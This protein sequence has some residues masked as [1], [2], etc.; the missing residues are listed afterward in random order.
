LYS[1]FEIT[2]SRE[3]S[4]LVQRAQ[5]DRS[6]RKRLRSLPKSLLAVSV[7]SLLGSNAK[8]ILLRQLEGVVIAA[9][10]RDRLRLG[11]LEI[12][13]AIAALALF[14]QFIAH[15]GPALL[16]ALDVRL[17]PRAAWFGLNTAV[18]LVLCAVRFGPGFVRTLELKRHQ[19]V[20]NRET[21]EAKRKQLEQRELLKRLQEGRKRR[22]Y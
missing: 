14:L 15:S 8:A 4:Q 21:Q 10:L 12:L 2:W 3:F 9:R 7:H 17:W 20:M 19:A 11:R 16:G 22:I 1:L 6:R 5:L 13:L 18:V